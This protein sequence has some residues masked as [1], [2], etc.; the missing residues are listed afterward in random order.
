[1]S[2]LSSILGLDND[3]ASVFDF[4]IAEFEKRSKYIGIDVGTVGN[5]GQT[6]A[7]ILRELGFHDSQVLGNEAFVALKNKLMGDEII[8]GPDK[9]KFWDKYKA[10]AILTADGLVSV[11]KN[12]IEMSQNFSSRTMNN[13]RSELIETIARNYAMSI[14]NLSYEEVKNKLINI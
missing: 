3:Q 7:E 14:P 9:D 5:I 11:N 10:S 6:S 2:F 12:D 13:F 8:E 4:Q 1:M